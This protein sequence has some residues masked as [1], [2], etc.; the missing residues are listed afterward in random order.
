MV[1]HVP[2]EKDVLAAFQSL[3]PDLSLHSARRGAIQDLVS[4][5]HT[6]EVV[7]QMSL[8]G[9]VIRPEAR[10]LLPYTQGL[11]FKERREREQLQLSLF[12][13]VSLG[14]LSAGERQPLCQ[15]WLK[16]AAAALL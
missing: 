10:G 16:P 14:L 9:Q 7:A 11:W 5:G 12:L 6:A 15:E 8:H 2:D 1:E 13:A 4:R 3:D